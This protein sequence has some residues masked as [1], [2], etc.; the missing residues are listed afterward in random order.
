MLRKIMIKPSKEVADELGSWLLLKCLAGYALWRPVTAAIAYCFNYNEN[1]K[2]VHLAY[3]TSL[4]AFVLYTAYQ[5]QKIIENAKAVE[6]PPS[7]TTHGLFAT[8]N[9][10]FESEFVSSLTSAIN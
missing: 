7:L 5:N 6:N 8:N 9:R 3:G 10:G 4:A 1:I 2:L